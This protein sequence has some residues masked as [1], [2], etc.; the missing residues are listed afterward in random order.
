MKSIVFLILMALNGLEAHAGPFQQAYE[1]ALSHDATLQGARAELASVQQNV[2]MARAALLPNV[3]ISVS[4]AAIEGTRTAPDSLG[5]QVESQLDYRAP[6]HSLNVRAPIL[7]REASL[8]LSFAKMQVHH[9]E[10]VYQVRKADL[11]ERLAAAYLQRLLSEQAVLLAKSHLEAAQVQH[12]A[13]QRKLDLGEGTKPESIDAQAVLEMAKVQLAEF[14]SQ[15]Y[16]DKLKLGQITGDTPLQLPRPAADT[17]VARMLLQ[18]A[19]PLGTLDAVLSQAEASNPTL[20]ARRYAVELAE[21]ALVRNASGHFP[22]LDFVGS[23]ST[24]RNESASSL[25][26][27]VSQQSLGLQL[28]L[29]LYSGG[30]VVASVRQ[31]QADLDKAS[32]ELLVAQQ[33]IA[34]ELSKAYFGMANGPGKLA[35]QRQAV[36]SSQLAWDAARLGLAKG[37]N[38]QVDVMLGQRKLVQTQRDQLQTLNETILAWVR[39]ALRLGLDADAIVSELD[40]LFTEP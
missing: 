19:A 20:L 34:L 25:N 38:T 7:N 33:G 22:R 14:Q 23:L 29:A 5:Q 26:Q 12:F 24:A 37:F 2:P 32:A 31:A 4:D 40:S 16:L 10:A 13:A 30:Y 35:A 6:A 39:L 8:K 1:A 28:T 9:A 21:T 18:R 36:A 3:S 17:A 11:F 27:S 15:L